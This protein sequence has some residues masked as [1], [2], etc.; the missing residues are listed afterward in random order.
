MGKIATFGALMWM[1]GLALGS[2]AG[3]GGVKS[4]FGLLLSGVVFTV[5]AV[6]LYRR[7]IRTQDS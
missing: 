4:P 6:F 1:G 5:V 2:W 3:S 7:H